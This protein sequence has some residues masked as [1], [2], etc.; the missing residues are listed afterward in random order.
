MQCFIRNITLFIL[1]V[2]VIVALVRPDRRIGDKIAGTKL[3]I[4]NP[5]TNNQ[6]DRSF[7]KYILPLVSAYALFIVLTFFLGKINFNIPQTRFVA[8]TYNA[9]KAKAMEKILTENF[10]QYYTVSVKF[11][12]SIENSKLK[13]VSVICS[14]KDPYLGDLEQTGHIGSQ[15]IEQIYALYPQYF[16][17][18]LVQYVYRSGNTMTRWNEVIGIKIKDDD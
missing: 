13:Y 2:E 14:F 18:G 7:K 6:G 17:N 12:D 1:P 10:S 5:E 11:Y 15:T 3:V 9:S 4:D 8:N 16:I